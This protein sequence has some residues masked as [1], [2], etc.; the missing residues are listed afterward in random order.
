M[1]EQLQNYFYNFLSSFFFIFMSTDLYFMDQSCFVL[2]IH[3]VSFITLFQLLSER[4]PFR[5]ILLLLC[6]PI[7]NAFIPK[8]TFKSVIIPK[9]RQKKKKTEKYPFQIAD[10]KFGWISYFSLIIVMQSLT[11]PIFILHSHHLHLL[12]LKPI[13]N[14]RTW[15]EWR[16]TTKFFSF[17]LS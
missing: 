16:W 3:I 13:Q 4:S 2:P 9:K 5:F 12:R 17:F 15:T 1:Y 8:T 11:A 7:K 14:C 10:V 6:L